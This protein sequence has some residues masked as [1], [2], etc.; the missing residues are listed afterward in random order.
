MVIAGTG[1]GFAGVG[2]VGVWVVSGMVAGV[3]ICGKIGSAET[4]VGS[5][6]GES[7]VASSGGDGLQSE[8]NDSDC[9]SD[10]A[11]AAN[12]GEGNCG[13][14][15]MAGHAI[16]G[17]PVSIDSSTANSGP[18]PEEPFGSW[19]ATAIS[20]AGSKISANSPVNDP[21]SSAKSLV[22]GL[23]TVSV[24]CDEPVC[25]T[26]GICSTTGPTDSKPTG[27]N[28]GSFGGANSRSR[29]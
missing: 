11:S 28:T 4:A 26:S 9:S 16:S 17:A 22:A 25:G 29:S 3:V 12:S 21:D 23:G 6:G 8:L 27:S 15:S 18:S 19:L 2:A 5:S 20:S 13:D 10:A 1:G 24:R 14:V 7:T